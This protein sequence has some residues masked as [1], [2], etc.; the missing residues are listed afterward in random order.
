MSIPNEARK[1]SAVVMNDKV[2]L[3]M[4]EEIFRTID[5]DVACQLFDD[6]YVEDPEFAKEQRDRLVS[7][8]RKYETN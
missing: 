2:I 7:I 6:E 5:D 4:L 8:V 1:V 3:K